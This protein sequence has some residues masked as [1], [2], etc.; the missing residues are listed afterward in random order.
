MLA[1]IT[2]TLLVGCIIGLIVSFNFIH[3]QQK[4]ITECVKLIDESL[5]ISTT[6]YDLV[7]TNSKENE[8]KLEKLTKDFHLFQ[9]SVVE[10][11]VATTE[12]LNGPRKTLNSMDLSFDKK[13]KD[14]LN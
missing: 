8:A 3:K 5:R 1:Y 10:F 14:K 6:A 7:D 13:D 11:C 4:I 9:E 2:L 12:R